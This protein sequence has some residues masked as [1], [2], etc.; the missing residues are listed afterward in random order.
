MDNWAAGGLAIGID[1]TTGTLSKYGFYKPGFGT[2]ST[3]H[4]TTKVEFDGYEIPYIKE[5]ISLA[6]KFH[7]Y[8]NDIHSIGW[9]IAITENGP[10][11]IEG[12]DNWEVSL[13][14]I[15]THGLQK[16]FEEYFMGNKN[17]H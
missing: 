17:T 7:S 11:I 1:A 8:L 9:D 2:K 12:N 3:S 6:K 4:P 13:V 15:C 5:A 14:Q 10:L 16:E